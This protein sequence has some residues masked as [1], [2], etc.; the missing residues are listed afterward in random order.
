MSGES[1]DWSRCDDPDVSIVWRGEGRGETPPQL[2]GPGSHQS[3]RLD[4]SEPNFSWNVG[5]PWRRGGLM[6]W[7]RG[8]VAVR[9]IVD[10]LCWLRPPGAALSH[11][12]GARTEE[13]CCLP[14]CLTPPEV[15]SILPPTPTSKIQGNT[16]PHC[17]TLYHTVPHYT[18][19]YHTVPHTGNYHKIE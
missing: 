13:L 4:S 9:K 3:G 12:G 15:S 17:T 10:M 8:S 1:P 7:L 6:L 5:A 11:W 16:V 18:T 2:T 14:G 19:L